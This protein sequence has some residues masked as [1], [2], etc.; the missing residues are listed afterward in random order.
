LRDS[1]ITARAGVQGGNILINFDPHPHFM[2]VDHCTISA[3]GFGGGLAG[4]LEIRSDYYFSN[5]SQ[6]FATGELKIESIDPN[7]ANGLT[8]LQRAPLDASAQLREQCS[9]RLGVDFSSFLLLISSKVFSSY[10]SAPC[11][12]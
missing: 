6:V 1:S 12:S 8:A 7:L 4:N 3:Q 11:N 2:F 5:E 10:P 9:R